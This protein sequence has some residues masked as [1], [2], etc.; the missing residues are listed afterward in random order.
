[1]GKGQFSARHLLVSQRH[2]LPAGL[3]TGGIDSEQG[4]GGDLPPNQTKLTTSSLKE[5][6]KWEE[7]E[8]QD[9]TSFPLQIQSLVRVGRSRTDEI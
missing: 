3:N 8:R 6:L 2:S 5:V 1:M 4:G 9:D 7:Y